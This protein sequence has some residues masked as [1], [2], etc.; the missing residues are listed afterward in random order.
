MIKLRLTF[1]GRVLLCLGMLAQSTG[2]GSSPA[3]LTQ[4][5]LAEKKHFAECLAYVY[6]PSFWISYNASLYFQARNEAQVQQ[7]EAMKT[8]RSNYLVLTNRETRHD[9]AAKLIAAS[10]IGESWQKK[11]LLPFS[12]TNQNLTP[13]LDKPLRV[14]PRYKLLQSS[15]QGDALVEQGDA[16]IQ[17]DEGV[18][19]V[20]NFGR[21]AGDASGTNALLI[22]EGEKKYSAGGERR[23]VDAFTNV[24]LSAEELAVL[25]RVVAAF[26][27]QAASLTQEVAAPKARE[28]FESYRARAT[29]SNPYMEYLLAKC[30]LEGKGTDRD[31]KVGLEWMDKAAK[32]GSGDARSYLETLGRKAP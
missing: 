13:T 8:A 25:N 29:E 17:D 20:M 3:D 5:M 22:K 30:Y 31:E 28:D 32:N 7:L 18:Y 16:L 11:I 26:L 15:G 10:G 1:I 19:F 23:T 24:S 2:K 12:E 4:Q 9:F 21:G 27:K 6:D 14:I